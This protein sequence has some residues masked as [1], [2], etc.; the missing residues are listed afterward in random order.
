MGGGGGA[1]GDADVGALSGL[2]E[3]A[4]A[5]R[6]LSEIKESNNRVAAHAQAHA[7]RKQQRKRYVAM[8][9]AALRIQT[10][11]RRMRVYDLMQAILAAGRMIKAGNIGVGI[12]GKE[13]MQA[14]NNSDFAIGQFRFLRQL[15]LVHGRYCYR[16]MAVFC[17]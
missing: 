7:R 9:A 11:A 1:D 5:W 16:R 12:I 2:D 15:L 10:A 3:V 14:V 6:E 17:Y 8:R 13:G 4:R